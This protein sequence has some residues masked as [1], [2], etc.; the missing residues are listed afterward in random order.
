[1][2]WEISD[3]CG[4]SFDFVA[5]IVVASLV[6]GLGLATNNTVMIVASMLVSPLMSPILAFTFGT[7]VRDL[8]LIKRGVY[9]EI[10]G[11]IVTFMVGMFVGVIFCPFADE[12]EWPTNEM[13]SRG[14]KTGLLVGLAFA[15]PSGA[16]VALSV[17]GGG[18]NALVGVAIAASLLPPVVN[19]GMCLTFGL[20]G[21]Q[22]GC[23]F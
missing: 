6:A 11:V 15:I 3:A 19:S 22:V 12:F 2:F 18:G 21:R 20:L 17:T 8:A 5:F 16:G 13:S 9:V 4:L 1:M 14:D 7:A 10:V 23:I